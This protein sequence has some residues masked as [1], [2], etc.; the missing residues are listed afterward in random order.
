M[1]HYSRSAAIALAIAALASL[2]ASAGASA[3]PANKV[4]KAFVSEMPMHHEMA[5]EMARMAVEQAEHGEVK[6]TAQK[7]I[8]AQMDEVGRLAK[9]AKRLGVEPTA[10]GDHMQMMDNLDILGLTMKQAGMGMGMGMDKLDGADPF[11]RQ[12]IDMMVAH[13]QGAIRMARV[14]L[15]RG[16]DRQLRGIARA[17]VSAQATEIRKMNE[18]RV[19]WYGA[20]SP[21]GGVPKG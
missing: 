10:D 2:G 4:D 16:N 9:I 21:S 18:W 11:D 13:H 19:D 3:A 17:I 5:I 12:F 6:S 15:K 14:E 7:I 1:K 20:P 8:K